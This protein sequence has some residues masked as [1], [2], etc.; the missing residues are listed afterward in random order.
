M[1]GKQYLKTLGKYYVV[2]MGMRRML[3]GSKSMD[4]GHILENVIY[5]ELRRRGFEVYVGKVDDMEV[6]FV[7]MNRDGITYFQVAAT[8]RGEETLARELAPL[9]K[10]A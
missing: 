5:L 9:R 3:L 10:M 1:K 8:V 7:A 4:V 6:D 2:D